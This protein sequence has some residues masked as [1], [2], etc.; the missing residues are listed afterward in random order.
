MRK[1]FLS[2]LLAAAWNNIH[3]QTI[4]VDALRREYHRIN[5]DS[6]NCAKLYNKVIKANNNDN[7]FLAYK[8]A[9]TAVMAGHIK[10][11]SEK[12]KLFNSGKKLLE[13]SIAAD[14]SDIETRFLRFTVQTNSPK[15]LGYNKQINADKNYILKNYPSLTNAAIKNMMLNFFSKTNYLTEA[16]KQKLKQ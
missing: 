12:L 4:S 8:G 13:Q 9:I 6:A 15:A 7:L 11:K 16:E 2:F 10:E 3:A 5:T 14:S 1:I